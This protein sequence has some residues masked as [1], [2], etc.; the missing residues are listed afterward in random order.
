M[1]IACPLYLNTRYARENQNEQVEYQ[2][3]EKENQSEKVRDKIE[4]RGPRFQKRT[5]TVDL[6]SIVN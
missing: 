3:G 4:E 5:N 1:V 6:L 2:G